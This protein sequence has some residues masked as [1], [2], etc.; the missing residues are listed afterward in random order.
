M[1]D[2]VRSWAR[3]LV[4]YNPLYALSALLLVYGCYYITGNPAITGDGLTNDYITFGTCHA[5]ELVIYAVGLL[6]LFRRRL[7]RDTVM[8]GVI[9][10]LVRYVPLLLALNFFIDPGPATGAVLFGV[11]VLLFA[12]KYEGM[13]RIA[14]LPVT[15]GQRVHQYVELLLLLGWFP[16]LL[17]NQRDAAAYHAWQFAGWLLLAVSVALWALARVQP[18]QAVG[19]DP[20]LTGGWPLAVSVAAN[21][22]GSVLILYCMNALTLGTVSGFLFLPLAVAF[23][24]VALML[25]RT[26]RLPGIDREPLLAL[27]T[28]LPPLLVLGVSFAPGACLVPSLSRWWYLGAM[29]VFYA[30]VALLNWWRWRGG[31]EWLGLLAAGLIAL[32]NVFNAVG[33]PDGSFSRELLTNYAVL[34]VVGIMAYLLVKRQAEGFLVA[35]VFFYGM[36]HA[37]ILRCGTHLLPTDTPGMPFL[38]LHFALIIALAYLILRRRWCVCLALVASLG[39]LAAVQANHLLTWK[40]GAPVAAVDALLLMFFAITRDPAILWAVL[41]QLLLLGVGA[42]Y[43]RV[44][45]WLGQANRGVLALGGS[46]LLIPAAVLLSLYK[47]RLLA[48]LTPPELPLDDAVPPADGGTGTAADE[49]APGAM[50]AG[51]DGYDGPALAESCGAECGPVMVAPGIWLPAREQSDATPAES[52]PPPPRPYL[53]LRDARPAPAAQSPAAPAPRRQAAPVRQASTNPLVLVLAGVLVV[54]VLAFCGRAL[55]PCGE[56]RSKVG[57]AAGDIGAFNSALALYQVDVKV[58][59]FPATTLMQLYSDN[60]DGWAGPYMATIT[61]DPWGN[62]YVYTSDGSTYTIQSLHNASYNKSETIRYIFNLGVMESY[63]L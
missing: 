21:A 27:A 23:G 30:G 11:S 26:C 43:G 5:Y 2:L 40:T 45:A 53:S 24:P 18:R 25:L 46:F 58:Q 38:M 3:R 32:V 7:W 19:V 6:V 44:A 31:A 39:Y 47:E 60:A 62:R 33:S 52:D 14:R 16:L 20:V 57:A 10:H 13:V 12:L 50:P 61:D 35:T 48:W 63:P 54:A 37:R 51:N 15:V 49:S 56:P 17:A 29:T 55:I 4:L 1:L 59:Q 8:L 28:W 22:V 42:G 9:F 34:V 41:G 36:F